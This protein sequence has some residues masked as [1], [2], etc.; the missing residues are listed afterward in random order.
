MGAREVEKEIDCDAEEL[1]ALEIETEKARLE[2]RTWSGTSYMM[3]EVDGIGGVMKKKV[4]KR[5]RVGL[6][7]KE[8]EDEREEGNYLGREQSGQNRSWCSWCERVVPGRRDTE[9]MG[10]DA[11][12]RVNSSSS[13]TSS[14]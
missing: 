5:V 14:S 10:N 13:S 1:A 2:G 8:Y 3:Q 12:D 4:K 11:L 9:A 6:V 7:V